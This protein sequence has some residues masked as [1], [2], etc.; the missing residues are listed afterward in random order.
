M[1]HRLVCL[2]S[3]L[4]L[5]PKRETVLVEQEREWCARERKEGWDGTCSSKPYVGALEGAEPW[6]EGSLLAEL[7][8]LP[9]RISDMGDSGRSLFSVLEPK[10]GYCRQNNRRV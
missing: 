6:V 1:L 5:H 10:I 2:G 8:R 4:T 3:V 9:V 7:L